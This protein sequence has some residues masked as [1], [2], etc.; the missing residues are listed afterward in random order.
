MVAGGLAVGHLLFRDGGDVPGCDPPA[1]VTVRMERRNGEVRFA[2]V[3]LRIEPGTTVRWKATRG[4]HTATAYHPDNG[5]L[6]LRIPSGARPWDSGYLTPDGESFSHTFPQEGVYDYFCRPHEAA[7]M[8]GR[9]VVARESAS[10][11]ADLPGGSGRRRDGDPAGLPGPARDAFPSVGTILRTG[12][13]E[14]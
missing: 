6:P 12:R 1:P 3:G 4:V 8:V 9:I 5:D 11:P 10:S 2:P 13:T 7:G 14:E